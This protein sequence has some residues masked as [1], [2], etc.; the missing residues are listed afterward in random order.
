MAEQGGNR[1]R[2]KGPFDVEEE[3]DY[4]FCPGCLEDVPE[5]EAKLFAYRCAKCFLCP[6]CSSL[7]QTQ[8]VSEGENVY[9]FG[10]SFCK[11]E[12]S[13]VGITAGEASELVLSRLKAERND[14]LDQLVSTLA[15]QMAE[16]MHGTSPVKVASA[17]TISTKYPAISAN[18]ISASSARDPFIPANQ[19]LIFSTS[20]HSHTLFSDNTCGE[21]G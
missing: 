11:W 16:I 21:G 6:I 5:V 10:C 15:S 13:S 19:P 8:C 4:V 18:A 3:I 20:T 2:L 12:S 14:P 7:L 9:M 1:A 17:S